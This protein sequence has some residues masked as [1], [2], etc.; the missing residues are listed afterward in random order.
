MVDH[1]LVILISRYSPDPFLTYM[2]TFLELIAS[3]INEITLT[4]HV[5]F[6]LTARTLTRV[7]IHNTTIPRISRVE[8][9]LKEGRKERN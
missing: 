8:K 7:P 4:P 5:I 3:V 2:G 6:R 9:A 1:K